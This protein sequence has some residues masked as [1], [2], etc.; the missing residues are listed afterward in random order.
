[1]SGAPP[2]PA[3]PLL[4]PPDPELDDP[5]EP[6]VDPP[7]L[8]PEPAPLDV[9][10][11]P[12][13]LLPPLLDPPELPVPEPLEPPDP[14]PPDAAPLEPPIHPL[15]WALSP[16]PNVAASHRHVHHETPCRA[17]LD[18]PFRAP[19]RTPPA[20]ERSRASRRTAHGFVEGLAL[21]R[22]QRKTTASRR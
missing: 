20:S 10:P 6:L 14:E 1:M 18:R 13:P 22:M 5:P 19:H 2:S 7:E 16:H 15:D 9:P 4:D 12:P 17:I 3:L 11:L 8:P 21:F